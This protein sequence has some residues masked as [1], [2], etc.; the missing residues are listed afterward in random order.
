MGTTRTFTIQGYADGCFSYHPRRLKDPRKRF[1]LSTTCEN[2]THT[3]P[4]PVD[5]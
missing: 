2:V 4:S 5:E 3:T 1:T